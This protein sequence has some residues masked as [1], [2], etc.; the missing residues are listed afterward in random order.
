MPSPGR[1]PRVPSWRRE[2]LRTNLWLVPSLLVAAAIA[3]FGVTYGLDRA[4]SAGSLRLP[5]WIAAGGSDAAR[6]VL[7]GVAAA[8]ITVA[9][10]VFSV[11]ILVLQLASQ[12]FGPRMLRNFI[13]DRSTQITLGL[14]V[15]T[16]VF[17]ILALGSVGTEGAGFVPHLTVTVCLALTLVDVAVLIYFI[18]HLATSIQL[19]TVVSSIAQD[20]AAAAEQLR[21]EADALDLGQPHAGASLEDLTRQLDGEG[22]TIPAARSGFLQAVGHARLIRIASSIDAVIRL[23][24]RPGHFVV[25]GLAVAV[26]WPADRAS[27]VSQALDRAHVIG[28]HRTL[29]QDVGLAVD[30]LVEIALRAL[31]PAVND[32]FTAL[33]CVDWI[34]TVLSQVT[35]RPLPEGVY[36]DGQGQIRLIDPVI[37][38]E[39]LVKRAFDKVRQAG[40][41][42]P[43]VLI[44]QLENLER[45]IRCTRN[46]AG[47]ALLLHHASMILHAGERSVPEPH[48]R[49]DV[50]AAYDAV[51]AAQAFAST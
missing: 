32:T 1:P 47:R 3:L 34:G 46:P 45:I 30:Q 13:R 11:T 22:T 8:V 2:A 10:V 51:V 18:H 35:V 36:R 9:G 12:Q 44:R 41:G 33:N 43:A 23:L 28:P 7:I 38:F 48:D 4:A 29:T 40:T 19:T 16:F 15:A 37:T 5:A 14:F 31:S 6:A 24:S 21:T 39:Q 20:F 42:N 17:S 26:V 25:E 49:L 27:D 50:R